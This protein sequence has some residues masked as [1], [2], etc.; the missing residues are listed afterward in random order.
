[1]RLSDSPSM[2]SPSYWRR[3]RLL[4][5]TLPLLAFLAG[6][7]A[8]VPN[9]D[10]GADFALPEGDPGLGRA[11]FLALQCHECHSIAGEELPVLPL[12]DDPYVELG[13]S[14][15]RVKSYE[16]L[17]TSIINPSHTLA[18]G[19][20]P[21]EVSYAGRSRMHTYN[22]HMT[23]QQLI[24]IVSFLH[25]HYDVEVPEFNYLDYDL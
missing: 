5:K 17:I 22:G 13:G 14:V 1:M 20:E 21:D 15:T 16:E 9:E 6:T 12:A 18:E 25:P 11:F 10:T 24:D 4:T 8:C 3:M 7:A 19:Y 2:P 23:V